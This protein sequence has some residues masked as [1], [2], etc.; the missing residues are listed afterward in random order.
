[1][2][3]INTNNEGFPSTPES[4]DPDFRNE[5]WRDKVSP[6]L[7]FPVIDVEEE[8]A[9]KLYRDELAKLACDE[10]TFLTL[11]Y[12][13]LDIHPEK[14]SAIMLE[15]DIDRIK[16][17]S[18]N[19]ANVGDMLKEKL[20]EKE[21]WQAD[22]PPDINIL[23]KAISSILSSELNMRFPNTQKTQQNNSSPTGRII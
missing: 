8:N 6:K 18:Q 15:Y 9:Q 4:K 12:E 1:M 10:K 3:A 20:I 22:N 5:S 11:V 13:T 7:A 17:D 14:R 21:F 19:W 16:N 23:R 2:V